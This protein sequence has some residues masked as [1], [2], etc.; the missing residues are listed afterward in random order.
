MF[1]D[2][3]DINLYNYQVGGFHKKRL[4]DQRGRLIKLHNQDHIGH[5]SRK[6]LLN[7]IEI[8]LK[9]NQNIIKI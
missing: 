5:G 8:E 6:K 3:S 2:K 4:L 7:L 1:L 9:F